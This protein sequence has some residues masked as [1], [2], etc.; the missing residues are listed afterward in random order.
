[1]RAAMGVCIV[2]GSIFCYINASQCFPRLVSFFCSRHADKTGERF[3]HIAG[4]YVVGIIGFIIAEVTM[5]VAARYIA[6]FLVCAIE[7][8][9][10]SSFET[11]SN[12][13]GPILC[14]IHYLLDMVLKLIAASTF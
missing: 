3:Y 5:N 13:D 12:A 1:V 7:Q 2:S 6:L 11:L 8:V 10:A 4:S 14:G 9:F